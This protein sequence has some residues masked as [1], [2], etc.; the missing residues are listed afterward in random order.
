MLD[1]LW[2]PTRSGILAFEAIP[3]GVLWDNGV[4]KCPIQVTIWGL[5]FIN[6]HSTL[7]ST[8]HEASG[9]FQCRLNP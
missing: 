9:E 1:V 4:G 8:D 5:C 3:M 7:V 2:D 6:V